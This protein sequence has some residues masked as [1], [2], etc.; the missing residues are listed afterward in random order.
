MAPLPQQR[1]KCSR[2]F[3]ITGV[4]FAGPVMLRTVHIEVVED[5]TSQAF[6]AALR[7][8]MARRGKP[9][10]VWSDNGTNFVGARKELATYV[11]YIGC[12]SVEE[13]ISWHFNPPSAPHFEGLWESAVKRAKYHLSRVLKDAQL[14]ITELQTLLCQIEACLNSRPLTP[15]SSDPSDLQALTPAHFLVGGPITMHLEPDLANEEQNSLRWW[16]YVQG[17]IQ[18]FWRR[19]QTE[20]LPQLQ[21]RGKWTTNSQELAVDDIVIV[22]DENMPP[23][24]WKLARVIDI[25]PGNDGRIRVVTIRTANKT[26]MRRPVIKLC[27][28]PVYETEK[29]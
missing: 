20:Y 12:G 16:H 5:L 23:A 17:L 27:R 25:H 4:D 11:K 19:W 10:E 22:K 26:E 24:K 6:I 28:L 13:A 14:T 8:F 21:I 7:R 9:N 15:M 29:K 2:P 1:V 3:T 18:S